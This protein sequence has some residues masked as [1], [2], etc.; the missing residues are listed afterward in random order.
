MTTQPAEDKAP[1]GAVL[2]VLDKKGK[3]T[4]TIPVQFNPASLRLTMSNNTDG[5]AAR[6]RQAQQYNGSGSTQL[7]VEL[8]FDTADE[9]TTE[10]PVDVRTR[11]AQVAQFVLPGGKGSKQAPPRV[12]F[13]WGSIA[14]AGVMTSLVE[15]LDFFSPDGIPL[16]AKATIDIKQQDPKFEALAAGAGAN[17]DSGAETAGESTSDATGNGPGTVTTEP[18]AGPDARTAEA[19]DGESAADFLARNDQPPE[20]WRA[21]AGLVGDAL[22]LAAGTSI[23]FSASLDVGVGIGVSAGFEAG[24]D[25]S[26]GAQA[27]L[28]SAPAQGVSAGIALAAAGGLSAAIEQTAID[29][30]TAVA[31]DSRAAFGTPAATASIGTA[32]VTSVGQVTTS[33]APAAQLTLVPRPLPPRADP[34]ATSYGRGVPLRDRVTPDASLPGAGG[35]TVIAPLRAPE[36]AARVAGPGCGC[37]CGG[38]TTGPRQSSTRSTPAVAA[39]SPRPIGLWGRSRPRKGCCG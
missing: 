23:D 34:R 6:G 4:K 28:D 27:G 32:S 21:V 15:E 12:Q 13:R 10:A 3:A 37:G 19:L 9:G 26:V 14:I 11:T 7:H 30:T 24:L 29:Q 20:A 16:R 8:E 31:N 39:P 25:V 38:A 18:P 17:P 36:Y 2:D 35:W 22:S 33:R 5:G 1:K